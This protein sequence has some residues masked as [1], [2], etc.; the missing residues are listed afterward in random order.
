MYIYIYICYIFIIIIIIIIIIVVII[1]TTTTTIIII[2][3]VNDNYYRTSASWS[4]GRT[5]RQT[6]AI[7]PIQDSLQS[8]A[9]DFGLLSGTAWNSGANV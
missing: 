3:I 9:E 6:P 1:T 4:C 2:I 5:L 8:T 7:P